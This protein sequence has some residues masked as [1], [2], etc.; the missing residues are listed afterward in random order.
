MTGGGS[1]RRA[2]LAAVASAAGVSVPTVSKVVN[3]R[4]DVAPETRA[5]ISA[6]LAE[7]GYIA[8][9]QAV[10]NRRCVPSI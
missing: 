10:R 9:V 5:R 8:G 1:A 3:G 6:L 2:T 4:T 7:H